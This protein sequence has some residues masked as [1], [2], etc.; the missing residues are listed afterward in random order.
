MS[1]AAPALLIF[2]GDCAFC[3]SAANWVVA[4]WVDPAQ[5]IP[6]Q[7][8]GGDGLADLGLT[9]EQAQ[10]AVWWVDEGGHLSRAHRA[11]GRSLIACEGP[12]RVAGHLLLTPP[13]SWVA[14]LGYGLVARY[15]HRLPGGTPACRLSDHD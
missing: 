12:W 7:R 11:V 13:I 9:V 15:R 6:W 2:D 10:H 4:R 14:S 1:R 8:L 3:T 5:A